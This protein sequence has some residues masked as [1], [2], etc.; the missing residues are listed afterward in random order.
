MKHKILLALLIGIQI[1]A[2][3]H[4]PPL[5]PGLANK[6]EKPDGNQEKGTKE[7]EV[8]RKPG[9]KNITGIAAWDNVLSPWLG[10]PY[11]YGGTTKSGV[12]CSGFTS[13]IYM[14][15]AKMSIPRTAAAQSGTG[16]PADKASLVVGDL[17]FFGESGKV[18][19]V[20]LYVGDGN[21]IHASSSRGVMVS[22]LE[23]SYWKP[24]YAKARRI[25]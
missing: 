18:S 2:C 20:G 13:N 1:F 14:E 15:K 16:S 8:K 9:V 7:P 5:A 10:T 21:F 3:G 22:P 19:H 23:D 17:V 25:L 4:L 11:L 24:R 6:T 12:D